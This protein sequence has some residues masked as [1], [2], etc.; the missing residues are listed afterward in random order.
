[1]PSSF[2]FLRIFGIDIRV[3]ITFFILPA[4]FS[5]IYARNYGYDVGLRAA[6]LILM[7]FA[8]IV[9]H[10]L[11]HSLQ[12]RRYGIRTSEIMLYPIGGISRME[13][14]PQKPEQEFSISIVG[15]FFNFILALAL[16]IP[17]YYALGRENLFAPSL[18]TW[19]RTFANAFWI[20]PVLG[21][22]NLIPA[23]PMDG[24]RIFRSALAGRVGYARATR[25]SVFMGRGFAILFLLLGVWLKSWMLA[26]V[27]LYVY[28]AASD[29][30][31]RLVFEE[32]LDEMRRKLQP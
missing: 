18:A 28:N 1:M 9:G 20:N 2:R 14:I 22:F 13:R 32:T 25:I 15:P 19:P 7:I 26:L 4:A 6:C 24:G 11:S 10:E 30:L 8:C 16:F 29:E 27:A 17:L 12:A 23:F 21:L 31:K 5:F 3:H